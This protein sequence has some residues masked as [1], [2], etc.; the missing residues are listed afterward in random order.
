MK[1]RRPRTRDSEEAHRDIGGYVPLDQHRCT[2]R[3]TPVNS[4]KCAP[5]WVPG[6][7]NDKFDKSNNKK[8]D[9]TGDTEF[10]SETKS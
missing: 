4:C 6:K 10:K 8:K 7:N 3:I 2:S 1:V 5:R 9:G